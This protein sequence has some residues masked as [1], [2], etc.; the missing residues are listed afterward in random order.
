MSKYVIEDS[1]ILLAVDGSENT[2]II[3]T[4]DS[5]IPSYTNGILYER[6]IHV[7]VDTL[8]LVIKAIAI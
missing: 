3:Y 6:G 2:T 8:I 4:T 5:S 7:P 1:K